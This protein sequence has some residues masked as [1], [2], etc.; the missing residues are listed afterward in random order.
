MQSLTRG[1]VRQA[2]V[3]SLL[4]SKRSLK[5][6]RNVALPFYFYNIRLEEYVATNDLMAVCVHNLLVIL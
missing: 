4:S 1:R 5:E 6:V 3:A 2:S